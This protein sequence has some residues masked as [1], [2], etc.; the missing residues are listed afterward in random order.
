MQQPHLTI[1]EANCKE[2]EKKNKQA[3][4]IRKYFFKLYES[5]AKQ[6]I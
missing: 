5:E 1:D 3:N 2:V 6:E 4:E